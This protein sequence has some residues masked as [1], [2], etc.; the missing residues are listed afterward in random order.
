[1]IVGDRRHLALAI[2]RIAEQ[3]NVIGR[4]GFAGSKIGKPPR[5]SAI[6]LP[7]RTLILS[8]H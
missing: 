2:L 6:L 7:L 8:V 1:V 3:E 4:D 5:R